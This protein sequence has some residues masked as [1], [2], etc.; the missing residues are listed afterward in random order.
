MSKF[1]DITGR[2]FGRLVV[3][4]LAGKDRH[5]EPM[6]NCLCDCGDTKRVRGRS[7]KD[8]HTKSC[9]CYKIEQTS[10]AQT[11]HGHLKNKLRTLIYVVWHAMMSRCYNPNNKYYKHYGGRG[12]RV[13]E[14]WHTFENFYADM[15]NPP[16]GMTLDRKDNDGDYCPC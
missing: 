3:Q 8:S 15:G 16:E 10:K 13:C 12:I 2:K 6:W 9:G 11:T 5:G 1:I 4:G 7:L 14:R